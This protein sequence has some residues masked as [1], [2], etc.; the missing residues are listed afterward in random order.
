VYDLDISLSPLFDENFGLDSSVQFPLD[1]LQ[2]VAVLPRN[3]TMCGRYT[4]TA[5]PE[6]VAN[7]FQFEELADLTPRYNIAPSQLVASVRNPSGSTRREGVW[8]RWGLIPSWAKDPAIGMKLINA[9]AE[10]VAEKPS[11]RKSFRQRRCLV[12]ADGFYEWQKDGRVKQPFYIRMIDERPFAFAGL[13]DHWLSADGQIIESCALLTTE[14]NEL[15]ARIHHRMPVLLAPEAYEEWLN[16]AQ[17][18]V[19]RLVPMLR[20]YPSEEMIANPVSRLV[21]NARF[22]DPRCI[23]VFAE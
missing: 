10:T 18:D 13:W 1:P 3:D 15:M 7:Q 21:N 11:F 14:P 23:E 9:R 20:P 12:L 5:I 19:D 6:V 8:L 22:D 4:L 2:P 16:P 17:Q